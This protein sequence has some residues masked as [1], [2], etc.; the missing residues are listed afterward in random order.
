M[1][2]LMF[3]WE[4]PPHISGGL[5]TACYG[6]TKGLSAIENLEITFVVP[7]LWGDEDFPNISL[8]G[9]DQIPVIRKQIQ[10]DELKAKLDYYELNSGLIPYLGTAEFDEIKSTNSIDPNRL[11]EVTNDGK[12]MFEGGYTRTLFQEIE[13]YALVAAQLAGEFDFDLI[14]VHDWMCI[15]A[16]LAAKYASGKPLVVHIHSTEF[17]RA[18]RSVNPEICAVEKKGIIEADRVLAVSRRTRAEIV[19]NYG[20][21]S[22]KVAVLHNAVDLSASELVKTTVQNKYATDK[23]VTFLGRMTSQKG[24]EYFIDAARLVVKEI[25]NVR[26]IMAGRGDLFEAMKQRVTMMKLD[27]FFEFPGFIPDEE[28]GEL[29]GYSDVFVMPSVSE[30]FGIVALEAMGA[31]LP[32]VVSKQSGVSEVVKH[33]AKVDYWDVKSMAAEICKILLNPKH[34]RTLSVMGRQEV[35]QLNWDQTAVRLAQIYNELIQK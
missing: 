12:L 35:A 8:I 27:G 33:V 17:D 34:R 10:F 4:F 19:H 11:I 32:V 15:P 28:I 3:G 18:G 26:F 6:L 21:D 24:P 13:N 29:F 7:R 22:A 25:K 16:G 30:P 14:H 2:V 1:R 20:V 9:A 23:V 31:G 5:G